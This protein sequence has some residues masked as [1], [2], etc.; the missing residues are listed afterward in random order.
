MRSDGRMHSHTHG[1]HNPGD[2]AEIM[3]LNVLVQEGNKFRTG[4]KAN[5]AQQFSDGITGQPLNAELVREARRQEPEYF[6]SKGVW[7]VRPRAEAFAKMGKAPITVKWIDVHQ[8]DDENP[9][10][11]SRLVAR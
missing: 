5:Q 4:T 1:L 9:K 6:A 7:H 3:L 8:G 11:R 2:D 10:Y